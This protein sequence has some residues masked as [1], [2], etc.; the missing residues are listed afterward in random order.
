[1]DGTRLRPSTWGEAYSSL[2]LLCS[3]WRV[4][5][6]CQQFMRVMQLS[7]RVGPLVLLP[8]VLGLHAPNPLKCS[9]IQVDGKSYDLSP[10]DK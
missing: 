9:N 6:E 7:C 1:M 5:S 8:V 2:L 4:F 3:D 10:L